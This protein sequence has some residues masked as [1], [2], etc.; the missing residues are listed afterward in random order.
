MGLDFEKK[1]NYQLQVK[2]DQP[3]HLLR[4]VLFLN[5][6]NEYHHTHFGNDLI[7]NDLMI[8]N[9]NYSSFNLYK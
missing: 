4:A 5:N 3:A 2:T 8:K 6:L 1:I 9:Y 7:R